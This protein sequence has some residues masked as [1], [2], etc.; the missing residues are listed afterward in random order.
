MF[1]GKIFGFFSGAFK[2]NNFLGRIFCFLHYHFR[3][4]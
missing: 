3:L 4:P 2:E 1:L